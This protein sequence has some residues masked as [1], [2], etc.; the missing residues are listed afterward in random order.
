MCIQLRE[1]IFCRIENIAYIC[2]PERGSSFKKI[3]LSK[4]ILG[5]NKEYEEE[6]RSV[7]EHMTDR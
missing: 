7:H 2:S 5:K 1:K 3:N 4:F 6:E